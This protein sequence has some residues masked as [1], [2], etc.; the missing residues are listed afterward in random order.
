MS[1]PS[2]VPVAHVPNPGSGRVLRGVLW[3]T[4]QACP[5][6]V[7][8]LDHERRRS[9]SSGFA[10]LVSQRM[11]ETHEAAGVPLRLQQP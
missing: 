10:V 11:V 4:C 3:I 6:T 8:V 2:V 9:T 1:N 7:A 5:V